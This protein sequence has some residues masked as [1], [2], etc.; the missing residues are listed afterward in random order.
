MNRYAAKT[1]VDSMKSRMEIERIVMK[2]GCA[3]FTYMINENDAVIGFKSHDRFVRMEIKLPTLEQASVNKAGQR[4]HQRQAAA[5]QEQQ[6][7][8][9]W[10]ALALVVKA[11]LESVELGV[12]TFQQEFM[13]Y[14]LLPDGSTVGEHTAPL[15]ESAYKTGVTPVL[16]LT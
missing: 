4:M 13:P 16:R 6:I 9:R 3:S 14:I 7:R 11:K 12:A 2:Y 8:Q 5:S 10:R 1:N 15:I